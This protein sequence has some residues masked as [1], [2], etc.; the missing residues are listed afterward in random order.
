M[1][2]VGSCAGASTRL[3]MYPW[4]ICRCRS[5]GYRLQPRRLASSR[6]RLTECAKH[7]WADGGGAHRPFLKTCCREWTKN[8]DEESNRRKERFGCALFISLF[9]GGYVKINCKKK[10]R[11]RIKGNHTE[12]IILGYVQI[13]R[14]SFGGASRGIRKTFSFISFRGVR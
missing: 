5:H 13:E 9:R 6:S 8:R 12:V 3:G 4:C 11:R 2:S 1:I 10:F 14:K 7:G